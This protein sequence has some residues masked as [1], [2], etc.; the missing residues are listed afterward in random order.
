MSQRVCSRDV[1]RLEVLLA[2]RSRSEEARSFNV[3]TSFPSKT[4]LSGSYDEGE[5]YACLSVLL[6]GSGWEFFH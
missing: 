6:F 2:S 5:T 3:L 1:P 4:V